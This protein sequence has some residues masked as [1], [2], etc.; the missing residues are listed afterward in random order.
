[1]KQFGFRHK[2]LLLAVALVVATQLVSLFPILDLMR[3]DSDEQARRTVGLAGVLFDEF[4]RS[5]SDQLLTTVN[6]L[7]SDYGFKQAFASGDH[8]TIRSALR[9]HADRAGATV[10][11]L[12]DLDGKVM[13]SSNGQ[14]RHERAPLTAQQIADEFPHHVVNIDGVPYQTVTVPLRAPLPVALVMMGFPIDGTLAEHLQNLTGLA[15]TFVASH[16]I[17]PQIL[18]STLPPDELADALDGLDTKRTDAQT[19]GAGSSAHLT[20]LRPFLNDR[21]DVYVAVQMPLA[22]ATAAYIRIRDILF[23]ITGLSLLLAIAGSF[24]LAKTITR[25]VQHLAA[26]ARRMREGVY[27]EP[28]DVRSSDELGELAG[29]FNAMQHAI[30]DRERRIFHQ[31]HHDSL[32]G[33]PNRDLT[34]GLLRDALERSKTLSVVSIGLDRLNGIV[35]SLGHRAG[36]DVV[37]LTAA[38]LRERLDDGKVL[39]HFS[40]HEFIVGLP[41]CDARQAVE[42]VEQQ[43]DRLRAGVRVAGANISLQVSGGVASYPE[44]SR[45]AAELCRRASSARSEALLGHQTAAVYRL[46]QEDRALKQIKIVGDF[47]QALAKDELRLYFQPKLDLT[48]REIYGAEALVR[49]QH[50]ELGLLPPAEFVDAIEQAGGIA[51]LTRWVLRAAVA[52]CAAWRDQGVNLGV[53]VNISVDDLTDEYLPYFLLDLVK[54]HRLAAAQLTLEVTESAIMHNVHKSL[55]VVNCIHELGFRLAVDDFGTGHSALTQLKRLPVDELKIDKSFVMS[56]D[57]QKDLAIVRAT[58]DLAHQLGLNVVA[59]GVEDDVA[60]ERLA[61]MGCEHA[62]GYGIGKPMPHEQFLPWLA[63]RRA[64]GR[65][66]VVPFA[67]PLPEVAAKSS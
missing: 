55:A 48:T 53:A 17:V 36:D 33:L 38:A 51:H 19:T 7:A 49:W 9:N 29:G 3:R 44:H 26:A 20:L 61:A 18:A 60:L 28:I 10:A 54:K 37:K 6:V 34:I 45:D 22:E 25:P 1:M 32:T 65:A 21:S 42:W 31:A 35:S 40:G 63:Q 58:I 50:P 2:I 66:G 14:D 16:G 47:P 12:L 30:A 46:G 15:V 13:V 41:E 4:M 11:L 59:E 27:S 24:W 8:S 64:A 23:A 52:R 62:Q 67:A 39:G 56:R 5:R 57:D 43:A